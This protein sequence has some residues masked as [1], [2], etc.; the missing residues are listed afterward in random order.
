MD[1]AVGRGTPGY[2]Y[3]DLEF[4]ARSHITTWT[5]Q[6]PTRKSKKKRVTICSAFRTYEAMNHV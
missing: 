5:F 2:R 3:L 1:L 6:I 4:I